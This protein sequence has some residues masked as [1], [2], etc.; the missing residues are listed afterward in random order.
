[1]VHIP[2]AKKD[3]RPWSGADILVEVLAIEE[4][5]KNITTSL[6]LSSRLLSSTTLAMTL[7]KASIAAT[8]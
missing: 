8:I 5:K 3:C 2:W 6:P 1:M 7:S 4:I